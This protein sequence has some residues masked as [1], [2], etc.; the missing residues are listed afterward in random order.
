[1]NREYCI[2]G[3]SDARD[4]G[5]V[6]MSWSTNGKNVRLKFVNHRDEPVQVYFELTRHDDDKNEN[7]L[8]GTI[9]LGANECRSMA[10]MLYA[11]PDRGFAL[12]VRRLE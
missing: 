3:I 12:I 5:G 2:N 11:R 7:P 4:I 9:F 6:D 10:N 1:M 8:T